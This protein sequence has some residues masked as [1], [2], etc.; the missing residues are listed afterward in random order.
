VQLDK[1][2]QRE[3]TKRQKEVE[4]RSK[5]TMMLK[6]RDFGPPDDLDIEM[7]DLR[8]QLSGA[9]NASQDP[10]QLEDSIERPPFPPAEIT[11]RLVPVFAGALHARSLPTTSD[12]L[13]PFSGR[14]LCADAIA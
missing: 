3:V 6:L 12:G 14:M 11:G 10:Q 13:C 2:K 7:T 5:Q 8:S 1:K 9:G 4:K